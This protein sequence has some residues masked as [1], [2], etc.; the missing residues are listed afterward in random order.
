MEKYLILGASSAIA[1]YFTARLGR[2]GRSVYELSS[3]K[4][5]RNAYSLD[6]LKN[7]I[8]ALTISL[9]QSIPQKAS[10]AKTRFQFPFSIST[11]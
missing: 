7:K 6:S 2:E 4:G 11:K 9:I 10:P 8:N 5:K 3:N 1:K